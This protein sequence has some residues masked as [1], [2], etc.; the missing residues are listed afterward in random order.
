MLSLRDLRSRRARR[1]FTLIELL[2]VIAIIAILIALLLPAVQQAREAARRSQCLNNLKQIGIAIHNHHDARGRFPYGYQSKVWA[3]DP[4]GTVPAGHFR[5]STLAELT[6]YL[7]QSVIYDKIDLTVPMIGGPDAQPTGE[8]PYAVFNQ[9][10]PYVRLAVPTFLCPS[11]PGERVSDDWGPVNYVSCAG[12]GLNGGDSAD[13]D[14]TFYLNSETR[15][16]DVTDGTSNTIFFSESTKGTGGTAPATAA[17]AD[18]ATDYRSL[19]TGDSLSAANCGTAPFKTD[20]GRRWADGAFPSGLFNAFLTPNSDEFD[21]LRHS[22]PA[23]KAARSRHT[24]GVNVL[25]GDGA[26]RFVGENVNIDTWR[27]LAARADGETIGPY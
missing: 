2:V 19:G 26:A 27:N 15:F 4:T 14:G 21:C 1:G 8:P 23:W 5:W 17:E 18:P 25:L 24:G 10:A 3:D 13:A 16:R 20:R 12:T 6:P 9:N 11:D 22:N 7:E